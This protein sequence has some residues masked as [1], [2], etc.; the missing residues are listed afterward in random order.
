MTFLMAIRIRREIWNH[1]Y[2]IVARDSKG[3][4]IT[5]SKWTP[6]NTIRKAATIFRQNRTFNPDIIRKPLINTVERIDYGKKR[7]IKVGYLNYQVV[8]VG[9]YKGKQIQARS[10][11]HSLSHKKSDAVDEAMESFLELL[12]QSQGLPYD[13]NE[14]KKFLSKVRGLKVGIVQYKR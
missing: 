10:Q 6:K 11:Q 1:H 7:I 12:A 8:V 9:F 13:A 4:L 14:G 2:R 5:H 3:S